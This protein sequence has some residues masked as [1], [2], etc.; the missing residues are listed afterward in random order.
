MRV[1]S[2]SFEKELLKSIHV[3]QNHPQYKVYL[4]YGLNRFYYGKELLNH[5]LTLLK[6]DE[7]KA[8]DVGCGVG[9]ISAAFRDENIA[10]ISSEFDM[11][12]KNLIRVFF[13]DI[14]KS[15]KL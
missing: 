6:R 10:I 8:L 5:L 7:M 1:S 2:P 9:G 3:A 4:D 14:G 12:Y 11:N 13:K 15:P